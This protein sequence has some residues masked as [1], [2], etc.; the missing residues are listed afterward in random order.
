MGI[1]PQ[2]LGKILEKHQPPDGGSALCLRGPGGDTL[3]L[4]PEGDH[5]EATYNVPMGPGETVTIQR[6][7]CVVGD[8]DKDLRLYMFKG[9]TVSYCER[10]CM[11]PGGQAQSAEID[12]DMKKADEALIKSADILFRKAIDEATENEGIKAVSAYKGV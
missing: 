11:G 10:L 6:N 3:V 1:D 12:E 2:K 9:G 8:V 4:Q 7:R 5:I